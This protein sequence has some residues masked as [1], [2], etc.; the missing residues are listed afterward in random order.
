MPLV[1]GRLANTKPELASPTAPHASHSKTGLMRKRMPP[2]DW[3]LLSSLPSSGPPNLR[4]AGELAGRLMISPSAI[5]NRLDRL[6][7]TGMIQRHPHPSDRRSVNIELTREGRAA[8]ESAIDLQAAKERLLSKTLQPGQKEALN[9]LLRT[10]M[11]SF[12]AALGP[13][14]R[15]A[16]IA[17]TWGEGGVEET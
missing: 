5:T 10:L 16:E 3:E 12:E 15:R 13:P 1:S 8:S 17:R 4:T 2:T 6:E 11:L 14:P 9:E 7:R